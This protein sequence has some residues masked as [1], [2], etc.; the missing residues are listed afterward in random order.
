MESEPEKKKKTVTIDPNDM[1][2][3]IASIGEMKNQFGEMRDQIK[4][5]SERVGN[6][7]QSVERP[8]RSEGVRS[9]GVASFA[10]G[11]SR[12]GS[13]K[14]SFA[15]NITFRSEP[16]ESLIGIGS[17]TPNNKDEEKEEIMDQ[18]S[19][20]SFEED[21]GD[22]ARQRKKEKTDSFLHGDAEPV[23]KSSTKGSFRGSEIRKLSRHS[24]IQS[25]VY[26]PDEASEDS[27]S[28][29]FPLLDKRA[30]R[31]LYSR[32][33]IYQQAKIAKEIPMP[34]RCLGILLG[35]VTVVLVWETTDLAMQQF[36]PKLEAR[37]VAYLVLAGSAA[38]SLILSHNW[39]MSTME[40][41]DSTLIP[42]FAY[43]LSTLFAAIGSWG[44]I[45]SSVQVLVPKKMQLFFWGAGG[46]LT[47]TGT[48]V[49]AWNTRHNVLL[50]IA[51]CATTLG[52]HDEEMGCASYGSL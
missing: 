47:L 34:I 50:D 51:S 48:I 26:D 39:I 28:E 42:S 49:Y 18:R 21:T 30:E 17:D 41:S 2:L 25:E 3:L 14:A 36:V 22:D 33:T 43:A 1:Q 11:L 19:S 23:R 46:V 7:E 12:K 37:L 44:C 38:I 35:F 40:A 24:S 52:L 5:V 16:S 10:G 29:E 8:S 15:R 6:V 13:R 31:G 27:S 20:V 45:A 4:N 32:G 9:E